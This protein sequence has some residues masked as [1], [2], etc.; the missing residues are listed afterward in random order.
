MIPKPQDRV[1]F[2][3]VTLN[4]RTKRAFL[5]AE[6]R[7]GFTLPI[8]QGSYNTGVAA[9][10]GTHDGGGAIDV[11]AA[12]MSKERRIKAVHALKDAGFA[13]WYRPPI[14]GLW[15]PH[16]HCILFGD[17][18]LAWLAKDQLKAFDQ[19]RD[20]LA[21]NQLDPTYRPVGGRK[22]GWLLNRPVARH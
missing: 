13:A 22:W 4:R 15:G 1:K 7:A 18:E 6:K 10:A 5:W 9:S 8:A 21:G 17:K 3:G 19:G 20:G 2:R 16:I 14:D 12:G 11:G